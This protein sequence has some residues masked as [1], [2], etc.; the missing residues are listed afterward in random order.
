MKYAKIMII[1]PA[2]QLIYYPELIAIAKVKRNGIFSIDSNT[3]VETKYN[4]DQHISITATYEYSKSA[5]LTACYDFINENGQVALTKDEDSFPAT[6]SN[7]KKKF[8]YDITLPSDAGR[9]ILKLY[10][11][12]GNYIS[13]SVKYNIEVE[14]TNTNNNARPRLEFEGEKTKDFNFN[15][16]IPE[17]ST[18]YKLILKSESEGKTSELVSKEFRSVNQKAKLE[19]VSDTPSILETGITYIFRVKITDPDDNTLKV[20]KGMDDKRGK[21]ETITKTSESTI[22]DIPMTPKDNLIGK[23]IT[24][25]L[26]VQDSSEEVSIS[27]KA[28]VIQQKPKFELIDSLEDTMDKNHADH[29]AV[30]GTIS[31]TIPKKTINA[32]FEMYDSSETLVKSGTLS[33]LETTD[34]LKSMEF[35]EKIEL[36]ETDNAQYTVK[37]FAKYDDIVSAFIKSISVQVHNSKVKLEFITEVPDEFEVNK[38]Y[39]IKVKIT[40]SDD[41]SV[42]V[43]I[44]INDKTYEFKKADLVDHALEKYFNFTLKRVA[45]NTRVTIYIYAE[46]SSKQRIHIS[47]EVTVIPAR[48]KFSLTEDISKNYVHSEVITVKYQYGIEDKEQ[49]VTA[50]YELYN[51]IPSLS[52]TQSGEFS[53]FTTGTDENSYYSSQENTISLP[54]KESTYKLILYS[55]VGE[56]KSKE[57]IVDDIGCPKVRLAQRSI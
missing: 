32:I 42:M 23:D 5:T 14:N 2:Q 4:Y 41:D 35:N 24:I 8:T 30:H 6:T 25:Y 29:I 1:S 52:L 26:Y 15:V 53:S 43:G 20:T 56:T 22:Y 18:V 34:T 16:P 36:P 57:I 54:N 21:A 39:P 33:T 19:F 31:L 7:Q 28:S 11:K 50:F 55:K 9:Y 51:T 44:G 13:T 12:N 27:H 3:V 10:A 37:I 46:D 45:L 17:P 47:K 48:P 38:Q 49:S 40:D